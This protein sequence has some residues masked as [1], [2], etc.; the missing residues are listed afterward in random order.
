MSYLD[1]D[2]NSRANKLR[3]DGLQSGP[4]I[5]GFGMHGGTF[6]T[7]LAKELLR[8]AEEERQKELRKKKL[9]QRQLKVERAK[10]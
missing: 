10:E 2:I 3:S 1:F 7:G 8:K 6:S 5:G 4:K 9:Q